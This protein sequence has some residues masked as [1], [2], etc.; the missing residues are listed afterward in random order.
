MRKRLVLS[1]GLSSLFISA[2]ACLIVWL[3]SQQQLH[4]RLDNELQGTASH[5][6]RRGIYEYY[7]A[8]RWQRDHPDEVAPKRTDIHTSYCLFDPET[9]K[10]YHHTD[11]LNS[12]QASSLL[13][14]SKNS[15]HHTTEISPQNHMRAYT[16]FVDMS[17]M[18][19]F[20][21]GPPIEFPKQLAVIVAKPLKDIHDSEQDL[22]IALL[23]VT[24]LSSSLCAISAAIIGSQTVRR[25]T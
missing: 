19:R 11:D 21:R 17:K 9:K 10:V 22:A 20:R 15:T 13:M 12:K 24:L 5:T 18:P 25:Q 6:A 3:F 14:L 7:L 2:I 1:I 23:I 4:Q 8:L 16:F